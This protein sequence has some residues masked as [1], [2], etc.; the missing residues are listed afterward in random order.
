MILAFR[1]VCKMTR[2]ETA[3]DLLNLTDEYLRLVSLLEECFR[4]GFIEMSQARKQ[5]GASRVGR[6]QY[7]KR[8]QPLVNV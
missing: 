3:F 8:M 6:L 2:D 7:D 1:I 4:R 5:M